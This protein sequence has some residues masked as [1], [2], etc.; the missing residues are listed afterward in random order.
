MHK[1]RCRAYPMR[2]RSRT[3]RTVL[4]CTVFIRKLNTSLVYHILSANFEVA[5]T[6]C[7]L[8]ERE[9]DRVHGSFYLISMCIP[10]VLNKPRDVFHFAKKKGCGLEL[11]RY[12]VTSVTR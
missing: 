4:Y 9:K 8:S 12:D 10:L 6:S 5:Q 1:W 11:E 2:S 7:L 3:I